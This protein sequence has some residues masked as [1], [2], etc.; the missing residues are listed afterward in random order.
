MLAP[1]S[2]P[3]KD[4]EKIKSLPFVAHIKSSALMSIAGLWCK[5]NG[6]DCHYGMPNPMYWHFKTAKDRDTFVSKGFG[7]LNV[8]SS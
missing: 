7:E 2:I 6:I 3:Q 5:E 1:G 4:Q 8:F